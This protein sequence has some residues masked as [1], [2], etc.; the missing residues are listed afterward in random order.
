MNIDD[1]VNNI[2][3]RKA[4]IKNEDSDVEY[5]LLC[6]SSEGNTD[7]VYPVALLERCYDGHVRIEYAENIIFLNSPNGE[8]YKHS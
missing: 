8:S 6:F 4:I 3:I 5:Y 7:E 2:Y 1:V